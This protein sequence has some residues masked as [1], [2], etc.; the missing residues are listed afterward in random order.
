MTEFLHHP[1]QRRTFLRTGRGLLAVPLLE[2]CAR[3]QQQ[4]T[5][6]N[7]TPPKR[8][9]FLGGGFGFTKD[10]FYP[11]QAGRF[12]D[13]GLTEGL[14]PMRRHRDDF[15]MVSN[16]TNVGATDPHGG[17]VSYL[18]G[19]NVAGTPGKRFH[20]SVSCDQL[21][22]RH[23]G[24]D[25]RFPALTLSAKEPDGGSNS[26]HG[27][28]LSLAW[29]DSGNPIPG[30]NR[31]L[32]LFYTIFANPNDS[33][34][35]LEA[36][37]K[38]K[39]SILDVVRLN[40]SAMQ[41]SLSRHDRD[42]L[43]EYFTGLRQIEQGLERQAKW[44][45]TPKPQA[46]MEAPDEGI[47]GEEA[48][49]LMYDMIIIALQ[50]D[51]TRVVS[52]RQPV[53]SL[54][55][56]MGISLKAHSLSH[57]GFSQPRIEA[58]RQRDQKCLSLF[59]HFLDRLKEARDMDG[60]RLFDQCIISYGTNLRSGHELRNVPALLS[61]GGAAQIR[62]G[63]HVMLPEEDTPLANYWLTLMQQAGLPLEQFSHSTGI[64]PE[65]LA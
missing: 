2:T 45:D 12:A 53:C 28:G 42:K 19:A 63:R 24:Q 40:G 17:S 1:Q 21:L 18:T 39:H 48:I 38:K 20:N 13:I 29:D 65:L 54:L 50:T 55:S 4:R 44:A 27:P 32:D 26:G 51:V 37:L 14:T 9:V 11:T 49:K 8:V 22:A 47:T 3:G 34:E 62:H 58:S 6:D 15:T 59:A 36:R 56:G 30:I 35:E 5:P 43:E 25:T 33:R 57:Y 52:Y 61:G 31:P 64:V 23:L 41:Q 10:S 46:S 7:R 60:S 16:L